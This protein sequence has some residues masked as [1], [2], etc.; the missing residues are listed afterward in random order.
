MYL[1]VVSILYMSYY[2]NMYLFNGPAN[3]FS[4]HSQGKVIATTEGYLLGGEASKLW[5]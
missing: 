4:S 5:L 3:S 2:N 1:K